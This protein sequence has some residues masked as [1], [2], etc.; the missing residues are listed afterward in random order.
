[1]VRDLFGAR[2]KSTLVQPQTL[3]TLEERVEVKQ[4]ELVQ[5]AKLKGVYDKKVLDMQL[6]LAQSRLF[7]EHAVDLMRRK[8]GS[9]TPGVDKEI[10]DKENEQMFE[11]LVEFL[12][13]IIY[14]PNQYRAK[15]VKRV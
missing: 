6:V 2:Q 3:P 7:R 4:R 11:E 14:H 8:A 12:R 15:A 5:L 1:M 9:Q 13:T 10:Y